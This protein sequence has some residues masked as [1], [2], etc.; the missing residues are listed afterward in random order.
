MQHNY[1]TYHLLPHSMNFSK[2]IEMMS[3][4]STTYNQKPITRSLDLPS[5]GWFLRQLSSSCCLETPVRFPT[6]TAARGNSA[7]ESAR[8]TLKWVKMTESSEKSN[9]HSFLELR[10]LYEFRIFSLSPGQVFLI[11]FV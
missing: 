1:I 5:W 11:N 10:T 4:H 7:P 9:S 6:A 3:N 8:L 2:N